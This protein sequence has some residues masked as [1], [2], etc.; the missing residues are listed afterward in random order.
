VSTITIEVTEEEERA[1]AEACKPYLQQI[2]FTPALMSVL[3]DIDLL[4]EQIRLPINA[5]RMAAFCKVF[6]LLTPEQIDSLFS[7]DA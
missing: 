2:N 6:K 4:P 7:T 5:A 1:A 3:Y